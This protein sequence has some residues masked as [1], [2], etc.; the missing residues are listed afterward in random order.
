LQVKF[1]SLIRVCIIV[2]KA[3]W[4]RIFFFFLQM[5]NSILSLIIFLDFSH[6][7]LI[8]N[9]NYMI[10]L[11]VQREVNDIIMRINIYS[12]VFKGCTHVLMVADKI[13]KMCPTSTFRLVGILHILQYVWLEFEF[14]Y[15]HLS[16][17]KVTILVPRLLDQKLKFQK[18]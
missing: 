15:F 14:C 16:S 11:I 7:L 13:L 6:E 1:D 12:K 2:T 3:I 10:K 4:T 9:L 5:N 17:Q 8:S 18:M